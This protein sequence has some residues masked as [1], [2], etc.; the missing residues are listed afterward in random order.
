MRTA[1]FQTLLSAW[2]L[3]AFP[4]FAQDGGVADGGEAPAS[5]EKKDVAPT[6]KPQTRYFEGMGRTPEE[7]RV[8]EELSRAL[9]TYEE[10][11]KEFRREVQLL[12]EKKYE[13]KRNTLANSY[14]K[15]IRDLEVIERK[16][17][18][19]AI[20]QFE[21]FLQ[22]Y[23]DDPKYTPDVMFRLAEL[24]YE[25]SSDDHI[26]AMRE[27]EE[28]LKKI[29]PESNV[30][31]PPEPVVDFSRS[32]ALYRQLINRFPAYRLNDGAYY[33]LGYCLE[34]Q[35]QFEESRAAYQEL[36]AKYPKSKFTTEAW[37]R[38]GEYYFD[39]YNEENALA[40]AAEAYEQAV[41]DAS[42]ALYD[43]ALYK[44]GWT[45]YRMDRFEDAVDRFLKLADH[46]EAQAKAK[47]EEEVGGD[48]R[49]EAL[50]YT[51]ISFADEKWGSLDKAQQKFAA[52][53]GRRYEAE[54]YRRMGDV[55]FDQTKH[56]EAIAAYQLV[57]Q[58]DPLNKDAPQIQQRI[59]QA[60][61]RDRRLEEAFAESS[62][63]ANM[64][65][66]GT[67]WHE[68]HKRDP[69]L[70]ATAQELAEKSLYSSA[71]YHHQQALVFKQE[72]K[73]EQAK[74]AFEVAAKAYGSYLSRFPRSKNA[75]E[76]QFYYAECLYNSFQFKEAGKQYAQ[77]RDSTQDNKFQADAA[78][79]AVLAWQKQLELEVRQK[80]V[81]EYKPVLS[82][83]RPEN[84]VIQPIPLAETEAALVTASDAFVKRLPAH[85][86]APGIAYKAA[87]L[88]YAHNDFPEA[89]RR[90]EEIIA[91]YPQNEVA[92]FAMNLTVE[93]LVT[94]KNWA[95]VEK[96]SARLAAKKE[97]IDPKSDLYK[98]LVK[99]KL[100]GRFKL[101]EEL[102]AKGDYDAAAAK[103]I[104]LVDEEPKHEFA[105]KALNNA[106]VAYESNRRFDS[107][108][109]LY[110]RIF[111]EYPSSK[112]ADAALFRVARNAYNS[113][114]FD[115]AVENYQRLVKDYPAS[116]DREAA[117]FNVANLLEGLQRY[118]EAAA[119]FLRYADL[120]P[121][122][123]DAPKNQ[124]RAALI[125]EK[126][127]DWAKEIR[128]LSEFVTK[129]SGKSAQAEL[130]VDA[131]RRIGDAYQK[132]NKDADA[133]KAYQAAMSDFD[134][135]NLKPEGAV[136]GAAASAQSCFK[137]AEY[138]FAAFDRL[139]IGGSK[140]AL[141]KSFTA[142]RNAVKKVND[143]YGACFKYKNLEMTLA[144]LYRRGFAL[145]RFGQTI[146]E[147]PVPPEVKRLGEE[148]VVLYQDALA[149]QTVVLEDKAVEAYAA[150]LAE[151]RKNRISNEWTKKTLEALNRFRPNEYPVLK[152]PKHALAKE[153]VYPDG[154]V[155]TLEGVVREQVVPQKLQG[156]DK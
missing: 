45:Y 81:P 27:Y 7:E 90:F 135:R 71:I 140:K 70:I 124:F 132:L 24:Y 12:I 97:V 85:E 4:A 143:A 76:M 115:K 43:K 53:G 96:V 38:I 110:E 88:F 150:T 22:R 99:F 6:E 92:Q 26:V 134:R 9:Q 154:L 86:K 44:L 55:Y 127:E 36:I 104:E 18:L 133:K 40:R 87:E 35:N 93:S 50:Q 155:P 136:L 13:E 52:L 66:P 153:P 33:L 61:E 89:R 31:P 117:L 107:A 151:A 111:R 37:V 46:Y 116:K 121:A 47:G 54:I 68:K 145:E 106:A 49:N 119:A 84:E 15:A 73:F 1:L 126:Q 103:Y 95:E 129:F 77:V 19:D 147:T 109:K 64:F 94:Q 108:L 2:G 65:S 30:T 62:K 123:E 112:L 41:T 59:V 28:Q 144:S 11:S 80:A 156:D 130:I 100:A 20:A 60:Y 32:I 152:E 128:A 105:D 142:K 39:A 16:E 91:A 67:P 63:L 118:D 23:P 138:E 29:D 74:S 75:Y 137:L 120:F 25:R 58:K 139:K 17:R 78:F 48:L 10:E 146:L 72:Q 101:A 122:S 3:A 51:A 131:K 57:L 114:D 82:K 79:S 141:E 14:E 69:D 56:L 98:E 113:Y 149:Q 125:Y 102:M 21:E 5:E 83:D 8:L 148:A 34:K 42:H